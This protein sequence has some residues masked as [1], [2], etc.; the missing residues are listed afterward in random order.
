MWRLFPPP[1][2]ESERF[3]GGGSSTALSC[4]R[5][6]LLGFGDMVG[7]L[8]NVEIKGERLVIW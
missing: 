8:T 2:R 3:L 7:A 1:I 4:V 5:E 6:A